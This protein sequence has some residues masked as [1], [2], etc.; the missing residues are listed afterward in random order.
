VEDFSEE[1]FDQVRFTKLHR[2]TIVLV[3][4]TKLVALRVEDGAVVWTSPP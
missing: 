4:I 1:Q 2:D 3:T